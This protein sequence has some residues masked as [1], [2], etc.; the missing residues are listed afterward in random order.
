MRTLGFAVALLLAAAIVP[1]MAGEAAYKCSGYMT[2]KCFND[3]QGVRCY[4]A[5]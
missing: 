1:V 3:G 2:Y 4:C 5:P